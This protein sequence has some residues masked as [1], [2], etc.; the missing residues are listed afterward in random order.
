MGER[1]EYYIRRRKALNTPED[2]LCDISD[3]MAG[4][5]TVVPSCADSYEFN[6]NLKLHVRQISLVFIMILIFN[7]EQVQGVL[8][9]GRRLDLYRTFENL[10]CGSNVAT[11]CWLLSLEKIYKAEGQLPQTIYK[12]VNLTYTLYYSYYCNFLL[13]D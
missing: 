7:I 2:Y 5:K 3:G 10:S 9:H 8:F 13:S 4:S 6:P 12:N 1:L 11:H